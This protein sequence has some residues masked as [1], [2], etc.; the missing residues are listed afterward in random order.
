M[1]HEKAHHPDESCNADE[2]EM[3]HDKLANP[4]LYPGELRICRVEI[5]EG[6]QQQCLEIVVSVSQT[7]RFSW[8][9]GIERADHSLKE[10]LLEDPDENAKQHDSRE[11]KEP[12]TGDSYATHSENPLL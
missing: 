9:P 1:S 4:P 12:S 2:P 3:G 5:T 6:E 7:V 11:W 10:A 8:L